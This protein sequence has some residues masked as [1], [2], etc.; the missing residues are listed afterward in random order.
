VIY[1][2]RENIFRKR[3]YI[4]KKKIYLEKE[5]VYRKRR[6]VYEK[7]AIYMNIY[8]FNSRENI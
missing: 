6:Y 2:E 8:V 1:L 7:E 5:D 4:Y 3:K